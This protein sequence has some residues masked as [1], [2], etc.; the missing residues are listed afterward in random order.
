MLLF[1]LPLSPALPGRAGTAEYSFVVIVD[2]DGQHLLG[3]ILTDDVLVQALDYFARARDAFG[4]KLSGPVRGAATAYPFLFE[5]FGTEPDTFIADVDAPS[6]PAIRRWASDSSLPQKEHT[7]I[8][9]PSTLPGPQRGTAA[10]T[11]VES[12]GRRSYRVA[13]KLM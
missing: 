1:R 11:R 7:I 6:S 5:N 12:R 3:P 4:S 2:G 10:D 13:A 9:L 8:A